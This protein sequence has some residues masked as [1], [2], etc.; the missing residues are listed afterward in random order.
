MTFLTGGLAVRPSNGRSQVTAAFAG[1]E[2]LTRALAV[3]LAPVRVNVLR[4]GFVDTPLWS[5]LPA[6]EV[7]AMRERA[8]AELP[9]R[10]LGTSE[11]VGHAA[12]FAMTNPYVTGAVIP[13]DG[14][15][16]LI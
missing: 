14:G 5:S 11:D 16:T 9:A 13:V 8:R 6:A 12:L 1:V 4:P 10:H 15:G 7:D 2:G 3:E